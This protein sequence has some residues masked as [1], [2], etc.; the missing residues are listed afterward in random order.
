MGFVQPTASKGRLSVVFS[1]LKDNST[2]SGIALPQAGS[3]SRPSGEAARRPHADQYRRKRAGI[4]S[5]AAP[6]WL[7][8]LK[9]EIII[10]N[11]CT[12]STIFIIVLYLLLW[13]CDFGASRSCVVTLDATPRGIRTQSRDAGDLAAKAR[14]S[15][16]RSQLETPA[17]PIG[18]T[19]EEPN[20]CAKPSRTRVDRRNTWL[21]VNRTA[22]N[23]E[24]R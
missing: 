6:C 17:G 11:Y 2:F 4:G 23:L 7:K 3:Q 13:N 1:A 10:H 16:I 22:K 15:A 24:H 14:G 8:I 12:F 5:A 19:D 9:R 20:D 21:V 18:G